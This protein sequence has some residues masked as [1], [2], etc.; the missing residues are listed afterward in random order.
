MWGD[1]TV[2]LYLRDLPAHHGFMIVGGIQEAIASV[3]DLRFSEE[4]IA[5]LQSQPLYAGLGVTFYESLRHF[6][7]SGDIW[8]IPEGTPV[9]PNEPILRITAPLPQIGLFEVMVTQAVGCAMAVATNAARMAMAA[10]G[11]SILDFGSRRVPGAETARAT[12]RAAFIG[13]CA[14][15][16]HALAARDAG[17]PVVG[18]ISDTMLAAYEDVTVA[19]DALSSHFPDGCHLNLPTEC[20]LD[21]ID[22]FERIHDRVQTVRVDHPDL[23]SISHQIRQRLDARGMEHTRILGSGRLDALTIRSLVDGNAPIDLFAVGD[24]L[25]EGIAGGGPPLCYRMSSFVRGTTPEPITGHWSAE[26][27][28]IKQVCRFADHDVVCAEVEVPE[29]VNAGGKP[30]LKPWVVDGVQNYAAPALR[31][32]RDHCTRSVH[33]LSPAVRQLIAP[34]THLVKPSTTV[35][36]WSK[37]GG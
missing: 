30:L 20:P 4:D 6:R 22:R 26:W 27:P 3:C 5:W 10:G 36:D 14:G 25:T 34:D 35:A 7:F 21:A 17:I 12:A 18:L 19:F 1:A 32:S 37:A 16:T 29:L 24:A 28:G 11:R 8:A 15:T 33:Q 31:E 2:D 23:E 13:G 9:F